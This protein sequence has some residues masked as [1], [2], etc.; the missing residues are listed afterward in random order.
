VIAG[1]V[2]REVA[3]NA[4]T[5]K[6]DFLVA[7]EQAMKRKRAEDQLAAQ[8][9]QPQPAPEPRS[10]VPVVAAPAPVVEE[11]PVSGLRIVPAG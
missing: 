11:A 5:N 6:H 2:D 4:A 8:Q 9:Q 1:R 10:E 3:A 7:L